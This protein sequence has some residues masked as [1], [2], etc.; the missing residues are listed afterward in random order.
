MVAFPDP[1]MVKRETP[2]VSN[3]NVF[4]TEADI[5]VVVDPVNFN[6]GLAED[7]AGNCSAPVIVDPVLATQMLLALTTSLAVIPLIVPS[8]VKAVT[9]ILSIS[10]RA[11]RR[12]LTDVPL[13]TFKICLSVL[14]DV[15]LFST[16]DALGIY[17]TS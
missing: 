9:V 12:E 1:S 7:P 2:F 8:T 17:I 5:P 10:V 14:S 6:E 11:L 16:L 13:G 4:A 3:D 15:I